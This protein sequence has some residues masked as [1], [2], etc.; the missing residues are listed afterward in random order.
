MIVIPRAVTRRGD[1]FYIPA[2]VG[3]C[4]GL[5]SKAA[6]FSRVHLF[7]DGYDRDPREIYEIPVVRRYVRRL[8]RD[9]PD[10]CA[11]LYPGE[12]LGALLACVYDVRTVRPAGS[13]RLQI[14]F[15]LDALEPCLAEMQDRLDRFCRCEFV[16]PEAA[17]A[18]RA[19]WA[20]LFGLLK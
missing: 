1:T 13:R 6:L 17:S 16:A 8:L 10:W 5:R 7:F 3:H 4:L 12:Q 9:W 11:M 14:E 15:Q 19:A 20:A 18:H 2:A